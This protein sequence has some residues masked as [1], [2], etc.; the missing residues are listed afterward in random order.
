MEL[1]RSSGVFFRPC[2]L[3][4]SIFVFCGCSQYSERAYIIPF[5][6]FGFLKY[7]SLDRGSVELEWYIKDSFSTP[8][9]VDVETG[10]G[11]KRVLYVSI[12]GKVVPDEKKWISARQAAGIE[13]LKNGRDG[14]MVHNVAKDIQRVFYRDAEGVHEI[15]EM[16]KLKG[17]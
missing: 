10:G 9:K 5:N 15:L 2:F 6:H 1:N 14:F 13:T 4:V 8:V 7:A 3:A 12:Y 11:D 17:E 16:R